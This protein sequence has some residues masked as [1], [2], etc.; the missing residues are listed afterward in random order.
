MSKDTSNF[1]DESKLNY[2]RSAAISSAKEKVEQINNEILRHREDF[3]AKE[4]ALI[5]EEAASYEKSKILESKYKITHAL[6]EH[7]M[8][9]KLELL[10]L[11]KNVASEI[12]AEIEKKLYEFHNSN[13]YYPF[14]SSLAVKCIKVCNKNVEITLSASDKQFETMLT[15]HIKMSVADLNLHF[16][17]DEKIVYGGIRVLD[18]ETKL[19][20]NETIDERL[21][22]EK[23]SF[24]L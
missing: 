20:I 12:F 19:L 17:Y 18:L 23:D 24:S 1:S 6:S 8:K 7:T 5:A 15:E 3:F 10:Q 11:R 14:L 13:E 22:N 9:C 16:S 21:N 2:F 4:Y